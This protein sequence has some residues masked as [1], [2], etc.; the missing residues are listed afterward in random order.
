[1]RSSANAQLE[2]LESQLDSALNVDL[3]VDG[4]AIQGRV[5][6]PGFERDLSSVAESVATARSAKIS[7]GLLMP[8]PPE[9]APAG[10]YLTGD[11]LVARFPGVRFSGNNQVDEGVEIG[12]GCEIS[13]SVIHGSLTRIG[14]N[15]QIR[16]SQIDNCK[17]LDGVSIRNAN[18][19]ESTLQSGAHVIG[20]QMDSSTVT[21]SSLIGEHASLMKAMVNNSKVYGA[22]SEADL[23]DST[24]E[25]EAAVWKS[26]L[27]QVS[28]KSDISNAQLTRCVV[29]APVT[30]GAHTE[31]DF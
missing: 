21:G 31:M 26:Q 13:D 14:L 4:N 16:S 19:R 30:S 22:V 11:A 2:Q 17:I 23:T 25:L 28:V 7:A 9:M 20:G 5:L 8:R 29:A 15:C 27:T 12:N 1:V 18:C 6:M 10:K 24:L 3:F